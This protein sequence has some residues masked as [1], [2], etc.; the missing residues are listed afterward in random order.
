MDM[1]I[2]EFHTIGLVNQNLVL[3]HRISIA[4]A[5][6]LSKEPM[7]L[8]TVFQ[9]MISK[10]FDGLRDTFALIKQNFEIV[11]RCLSRSLPRALSI[12][13]RLRARL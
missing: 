8:R 7:V 4:V 3:I 9:E 12:S 6:K 11:E 2:E 1:I 13:T 10:L 5:R